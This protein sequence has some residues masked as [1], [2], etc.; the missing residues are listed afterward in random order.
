MVHHVQIISN[1]QTTILST[2]NSFASCQAALERRSS[3]RQLVRDIL[4]GTGELGP[5][6]GDPL[7]MTT[8]W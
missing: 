7:V 4:D 6:V 8:L 2:P 5:T 1:L 3:G